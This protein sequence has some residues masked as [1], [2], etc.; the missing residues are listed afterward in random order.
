M[1]PTLV[2]RR[3]YDAL[4]ARHGPDVR[5]ADIAYLR[6]LHLAASTTERE[7]AAALEALLDGEG[8][9][10]VDQLKALVGPEPTPAPAM[11]APQVDLDAYDAL[12]GGEVAR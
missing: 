3:A 1:F 8:L 7:V 9:R 4:L 6:I 10:D 11:V 12:L 5:R 2:F